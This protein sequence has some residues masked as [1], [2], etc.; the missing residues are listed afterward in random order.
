MIEKKFVLRN[1]TGMHARPAS[2]FVKAASAYSSEIFLVKDGEKY[3]AKSI[4]GLLSMGASQGTELLL[5]VDGDDEKTATKELLEI[6][7]NMN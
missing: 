4:L 3:N 7:E 1:E 2:V 5:I 6:I